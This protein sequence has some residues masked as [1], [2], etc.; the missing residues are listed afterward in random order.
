METPENNVFIQLTSV[1]S[2]A[3]AVFSGICAWL[4][5]KLS[6]KIRDELKSD[7]IIIASKLINPGLS[8]PSHDDCVIFCT[9]FNKSKR[10]TFV[11]KVEAFNTSGKMISITWSGTITQLGNPIKPCELIG[12]VDT[13]E[14]F[15]RKDDGKEMEDC[16]LKIHHSFSSSPLN[17]MFSPYED[18]N[19]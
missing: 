7:E 16:L 2:V 9:L 18:G 15:V 17:V 5:F 11:N 4:S 6:I 1:A 3:A 13:H 19:N 8:T 12:I 14:L 10:K